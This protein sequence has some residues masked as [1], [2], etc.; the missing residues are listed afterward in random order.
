MLLH[1]QLLRF[2][3][4]KTILPF[5][6]FLALLG[7]GCGDRANPEQAIAEDDALT[8]SSDVESLA[9]AMLAAKTDAK[10]TD[11]LAAHPDMERSTAYEIQLQALATES[12][13]EDYLV[14]WKMGGTRMTDPSA[15]PDPSFAYILRS[16]SFPDAVSRSASAY[17]DG[18]LLVE[19]EIAFIMG[20]D[21]Q[22]S[23]H[24]KDDVR[25]AVAAVAGAIEL[26]DVRA[27]PGDDGVALGS[28]QMIAANLSHAGLVLTTQRKPIDEVDLAAEMARAYIGDEEKASGAGSQI[29][30]TNALDALHWIA[31]ALPEH[32]RHLRAGDVVITG[33]LYDNPT[34]TAGNTVRVEFASFGSISVSMED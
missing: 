25:E 2:M 19:A 15:T 23:A 13:G 22:G 26:I 32:G 21:L 34:L 31:N 17:V 10:A 28:N 33:S 4:K 6:L 5:T 12:A 16:D 14:G 30:N 11:A 7:T 18:D 3:M 9:G 24:T 29:M 27:V 1:S 8:E 20:K